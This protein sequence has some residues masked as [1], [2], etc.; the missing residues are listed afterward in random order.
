MSWLSG[1][2]SLLATFPVSRR[3]LVDAPKQ[4]VSRFLGCYQPS[5][6]ARRGIAMHYHPTTV[7]SLVV[8]GLINQLGMKDV[9]E[10]VHKQFPEIDRHTLWESYNIAL[11]VLAVAAEP[12]ARARSGPKQ[13]AANWLSL[14]SMLH[15]AEKRKPAAR[16]T[17]GRRSSPAGFK[18]PTRPGVALAICACNVRARIVLRE[19]KER[20]GSRVRSITSAEPGKP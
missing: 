4:H 19:K 2:S 10:L 20:F 6:K 1:G 16:G 3:G 5:S 7:S 12:A 14:A 9:E 18:V 11:V 15:Q 17:E 13:P 8:R